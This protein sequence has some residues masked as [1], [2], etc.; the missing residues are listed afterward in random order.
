MRTYTFSGDCISHDNRAAFTIRYDSNNPIKLV[1]DPSLSQKPTIKGGSGNALYIRTSTNTTIDGLK[2]VG[3]DSSI[4][5]I[6]L[7]NN[8]STLT[9]INSDLVGGTKQDGTKGPAL[10]IDGGVILGN[11]STIDGGVYLNDGAKL[12]IDNSTSNTIN[13]VR[14]NGDESGALQVQDSSSVTITDTL[15]YNRNLSIRGPVALQDGATLLTNR[16]SLTDGFINGLSNKNEINLATWNVNQ[17]FI[18]DAAHNSVK[19]FKSWTIRSKAKVD[20]SSLLNADTRLGYG[21]ELELNN[22]TA[23]RFREKK[24]TN[25]SGTIK[26]SGNSYFDGLPD[27]SIIVNNGYMRFAEGSTLTTARRQG[28]SA[29]KFKDLYDKFIKNIDDKWQATLEVENRDFSN[30]YNLYDIPNKF[31]NLTITRGDVTVQDIARVTTRVV[32]TGF[33]SSLIIRPKDRLTIRPNK[34]T[35]DG[36]LYIYNSN[37]MAGAISQSRLTFLND[38]VIIEKGNHNFGSGNSDIVYVGG[39][40]EAPV[41]LSN[42]VVMNSRIIVVNAGSLYA[43]LDEFDSSTR[44]RRDVG[45]N[46]GSYTHIVPTIIM[47]GTGTSITVDVKSPTEY[48][49]L[50]STGSILI[51]DNS[52]LFIK[53]RNYSGQEATLNDVLSVGGAGFSGTFAKVVDDSALFKFIPIYSPNSMSLKVQKDAS[54]TDIIRDTINKSSDDIA[55]AADSIKPISKMLD[56]VLD[57]DS[58]SPIAK[59]FYGLTAGEEVAKAMVEIQ[60]ALGTKMNLFISNL[61]KS[62]QNQIDQSDDSK[63]WVNPIYSSSLNDSSYGIS[64]YKSKDYGVAFGAHRYDDNGLK[65]GVAF[66]FINSALDSKGFLQQ[67]IRSNYFQAGIYASKSLANDSDMGMYFNVGRANLDTNRHIGFAKLNARGSVN[68]NV[69]NAGVMASKTFRLKSL[70]LTPFA[71]MDYMHISTNSYSENS[72]KELSLK[73]FEQTQNLITTTA[74]VKLS[75]Q[76]TDNLEINTKF[77]LNYFMNFDNGVRAKLI[78]TNG[79]DFRIKNSQYDRLS[80]ESSL[81]LNYKVN[82]KFTLSANANTNLAKHT[83]SIGGNLGVKLSF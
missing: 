47:Y 24:I 62:V 40:E 11:G 77:A 20:D 81:G 31:K 10:V 70:S 30:P 28:E 57:K 3:G 9:I 43:T 45:S 27:G 76:I 83:K 17:V 49:K 12:T 21:S 38:G 41:I 29:D 14:I 73:V 58:K 42:G 64:G 2:I 80:L 6:F 26:F 51:G 78:S 7:P 35:N 44:R 50:H 46:D 22:F 71:K 34:I 61:S 72:A 56:E 68:A 8:D 48:T 67:K 25:N 52:V 37:I 66:G 36:S 69:I 33:V 65:L 59:Y 54:I 79:S 5:L 4:A 16:D 75:D 53:A 60:P 13:N 63:V 1:A 18:P 19:D 39:T 82:D 15:E 32:S 74:G 55:K 23:T